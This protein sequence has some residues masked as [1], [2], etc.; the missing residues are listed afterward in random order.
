MKKEQ[1]SLIAILFSALTVIFVLSACISEN[2]AYEQQILIS[3]N[4]LEL[5]Q[6]ENKGLIANRNDT[7]EAERPEERLIIGE[8]TQYKNQQVRRM[9]WIAESENVDH[10][11]IQYPEIWRSWESEN[12]DLIESINNTIREVS[13]SRYRELID[14]LEME[15]ILDIELNQLVFQQSYRI[16]SINDDIIS[17]SFHGAHFMNGHPNFFKTAL[18]IDLQTGEIL[19]LADFITIQAFENSI[20][21]GEFEL[22]D[23][24]LSISDIAVILSHMSLSEEENIDGFYITNDENICVIISLPRSA[25]FNATICVHEMRE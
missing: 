20:S 17:I 19:S 4:E 21:I 5:L 6:H 18:T 13:I 8:I 16:E 11:I 12:P 14:T 7:V 9:I 15:A 1:I 24:I 25:G 22:R 10:S 3:E 23:T 2:P